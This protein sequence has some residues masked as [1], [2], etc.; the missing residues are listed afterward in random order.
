MSF[1]FRVISAPF[2]M[3]PGLRRLAPGAIQLTPQDPADPACQAKL[4][5][6]T[7]SPRQA[8]LAVP[9]FDPGP[10]LDALSRHAATEHPGHWV[11][12]PGGAAEAPSLGWRLAQ[13]RLS[14]QG[15]RPLGAAIAS[16]APGWRLAGLLSLA[17][18]E[19]FAVL[20]AEGHIP[21]LAVCLPS[22]WAPED[23]VGRSF[24]QAHAPVADN[25]RLLAAAD[26]LAR[27]VM[28][29]DRWERFVWTVSPD[30]GLDQHPRRVEARRW[31]D[32]SNAAAI[33]DAAML[34]T[35][36]QTFIP[37]PTRDQ[38]V[39]TIRVDVTPLASALRGPDDARRLHDALSTMSDA[40]LSYRGLTSVRAPLLDFL[41]RRAQAGPDPLSLR[42]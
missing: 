13:G 8:L 35:E 7:R 11:R 3:Q 22:H 28:G 27:L 20:T 31:P 21:W 36:R 12:H 38:A 16:L 17:F 26:A 39:F 33:A 2:R 9:G 23:K 37:L 40:V 30:P 41:A 25:T 19:D 1:D 14:G 29:P 32:A 6:L 34:R 18:R 4:Q 15:A 5:V 42:P 10:A 24:A